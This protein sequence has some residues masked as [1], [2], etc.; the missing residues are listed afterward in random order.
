MHFGLVLRCTLVNWTE[1]LAAPAPWDGVSQGY[2]PQ[3]S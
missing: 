3:P 1:A 2:G